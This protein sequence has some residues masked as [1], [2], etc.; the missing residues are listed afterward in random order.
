MKRE[1]WPAD[2]RISETPIFLTR[3]FTDE[4]TWRRDDDRQAQTHSP[5]FAR[6]AAA[7]FRPDWKCRTKHR[8]RIFSSSI[9]A[10]ATKTAG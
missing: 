10:F 3:E 9:S 2:F 5:E 1:S 7:R 4:V 6:H 8:T